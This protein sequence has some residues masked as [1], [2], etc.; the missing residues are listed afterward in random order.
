M[1][2]FAD[3]MINLVFNYYKMKQ[4]R[5]V[6]LAL[7]AAMIQAG[8]TRLDQCHFFARLPSGAAFGVAAVLAGVFWARLRFEASDVGVAAATARAV[9]LAGVLAASCAFLAGALFSMFSVVM[10]VVMAVC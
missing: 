4:G 9:F 7:S 8:E 2:V 5:A 6:T 1:D 10:V 3:S